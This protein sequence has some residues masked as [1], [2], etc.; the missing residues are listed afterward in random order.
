MKWT[1]PQCPHPDF[2]QNSCLIV[3]Y[4]PHKVGVGVGKVRNLQLKPP[5]I[6]T[7]LWWRQPRS[8]V[9]YKAS[10]ELNRKVTHDYLKE[11]EKKGKKGVEGRGG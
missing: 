3:S 11:E 2:N 5:L 9:W 7:L 10:S 6:Y 4:V 1:G 8:V